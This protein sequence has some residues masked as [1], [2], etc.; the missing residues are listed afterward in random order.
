MI[1]LEQLKEPEQIRS[2]M[3]NKQRSLIAL[4][5]RLTAVNQ[6]MTGMPGA[7]GNNKM[8]VLMAEYIDRKEE[9]QELQEKLDQ[10]CEALE[11]DIRE[12]TSG[13]DYTRLILTMHYLYG[14]GWERTAAGIGVGYSP[15]AVRMHVTR[16]LKG[17]RPVH[18]Q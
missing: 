16:W 12:E 13:D 3:R 1:T 2:V 9:L 5:T 7:H 11:A 15:D 14:L 6:P 10:T 18:E 4:E 17:K 8:E